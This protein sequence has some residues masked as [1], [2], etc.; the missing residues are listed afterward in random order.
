MPQVADPR[1][2]RTLAEHRA[3]LTGAGD[4][5]AIVGD[6]K[7]GAHARLLIDVFA[8]A[9]LHRNL[10]DDLPH[11]KRHHDRHFAIEID[12]RLLLHDR[13]ALVAIARVMRVNNRPDAVLELRDHLA[14]AIERGRVGGKQ[15]QHV[16]VERHRVA[17][18]LH[19]AL[20]QDVEHADLHQLV[21]FRQFVHREDAA[22]HAG[23]QPEVQG[24]FGR[25][26]HPAS[27]LGRVDLANDV[28]ELRAGRQTLGVT[29]F[30]PPPADGHLL[31]RSVLDQLATDAG[32][33][34]QRV[35]VQRGLGDV[36]ERN[37]LVKKTDQLPHQPALG[38]ALLAEKQ[39]V[40]PGQQGDVDLGDDR[41][42]EAD[43]AGKQF[44]AGGKHGHE[45]VVDFPLDRF[46]SPGAG[47]QVAE[48]GGLGHVHL[49]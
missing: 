2:G 19:V 39:H 28:G 42:V 6:R 4:H 40:V 27:Q 38:L 30:A 5:R 35:V 23:N 26:A 22:V 13:N 47:Q 44:V 33:R 16:D 21:Q 37:R 8:A 34:P 17:A 3:P 29:I 14:A 24:V 25:H 46:R 1:H 43:N 7:T 49:P 41:V 36:D 31:G 15:D 20:F 45:V 9:G 18:N 32:D 12:R 11:E 10:F 48:V